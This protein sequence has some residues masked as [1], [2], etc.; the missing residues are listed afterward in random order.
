[1]PTDPRDSPSILI[2][3]ETLVVQDPSAPRP[4][5][6]AA[7]ALERLGWVGRP[8]VL[9]A[10]ELLGRRL[11]AAP[12]ERADWVRTA[13]RVPDLAVAAFDEPAA[14]RAGDDAER[15]AID[16][17][18][19]IRSAWNADWLV[20]GRASSVGPA[21]RADLV[22]VRIGPRASGA[23]ATIERADHEARDLLDAVS[24]ILASDTFAAEPRP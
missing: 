10:G 23:A 2:T 1:M 14:D 15:D 18:A 8:V 24:Q 3:L 22:V 21:R 12:D 13:F 16:H 7:A 9:A 6:D 4:L 11:P 5:A 20:T 17:W 19:A